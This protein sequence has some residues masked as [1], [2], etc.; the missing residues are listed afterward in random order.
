MNEEGWL[1]GSG[2]FDLTPSW[3]GNVA[4]VARHSDALGGLSDR[5]IEFRAARDLGE[6][7]EI[8]PMIRANYARTNSGLKRREIQTALAATWKTNVSGWGLAL[9]GRLEYRAFDE[10]TPDGWRHRLRLRVTAPVAAGSPWTPYLT[11]ETFHESGDSYWDQNRLFIGS[12][13]RLN[14]TWTADGFLGWRHIPGAEEISDSVI[15]GV[16]FRAR[17]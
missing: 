1:Y 17:W 5:F 3:R 15:A 16:G 8:M 9:R 13:Y 14:A 6:S 11:N 10:V 2:H 12:R 7:W 4:L